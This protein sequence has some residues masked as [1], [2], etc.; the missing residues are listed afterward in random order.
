[1]PKTYQECVDILRSDIEKLPDEYKNINLVENP[2]IENNPWSKFCFG[3]VTADKHKNRL[4]NFMKL[5]KPYFD[6]F[7]IDYFYVK[8]RQ[9]DE[10]VDDVPFTVDTETHEFY[11]NA[12]ESYETLAHKLSIFYDFI[13]R[14]TD[15][16]Y[17]IKI[18]DG[19]LVC[20]KEIVRFL[21]HD[22]AGSHMKPTSNRIHRGKCKDKVLNK[23]DLDFLHDWTA[24]D[25]NEDWTL[26]KINKIKKITYVGG[27]YGYRLGRNA[28]EKITQKKYRD[29]VLSVPLSYEDVILGQICYFENIKPKYLICGKYH[30]IS[31]SDKWIT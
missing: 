16:E 4:N 17:V 2:D 14:E 25:V 9:L 3:I 8:A 29:H 20:F 21:S 26:D 10:T 12:K 22:Y 6:R 28:L 1:M 5:T 7:G 15:Y 19:C 11:A 30:F 27:G 18:D 23:T 31:G 13:Y 24:V